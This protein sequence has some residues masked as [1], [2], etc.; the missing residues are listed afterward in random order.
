VRKLII[1]LVVSLTFSGCAISPS[2][3]PQEIAQRSSTTLDG[4]YFLYYVPSSGSIA[5]ATFIAL[6]KSS[7]TSST[8]EDLSVK[9][10]QAAV[11]K[12]PVSVGGPNPQKTAEVILNAANLCGENDLSGLTLLYV[13]SSKYSAIINEAVS[14]KGVKYQFVELG[15]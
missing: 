2:V 15:L 8:A 6:S 12:K 4:A 3:G 9:L 5:D 11:S 1:F 10:K 7:G 13:G 14:N